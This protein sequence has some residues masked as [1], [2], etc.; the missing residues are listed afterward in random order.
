MKR[1]ITP[2]QLALFSRSPV[3][4]AWWEELNKIDPESAPKPQPDSL[5][6]L[7]IDFGHE[8][9][10][11]LIN[12]LIAQ[13]YRVNV[14]W[15][16]GKMTSLNFQETLDAMHNGDDYIYQACLQN[17]EL[18]GSVD[19]LQRIDKSSKLGP[20]SY[21][22]I[23]CKLSSHPKPIY[24]VQG[25]AY[26]E[27]LEPI[28]GTRPQHFKLYLGGKKFEKGADG[29]LVNDYWMW[30]RRLRDRYRKFLDTFDSNKQPEHAPGDHGHWSSFIE[31]ELVKKRDLILVA[32]MR[33]SQ[34]EK[35]IKAGIST[36]EQLANK[37]ANKSNTTTIP[38][39]DEN[40]FIRLKE[41][42]EIQTSPMGEGGR[43]PYKVRPL[44]E[45]TK[46]L[47]ML[48]E[49]DTGDIW[50]DMEG[51]PNPLTGKKLEYLFGACYKN[52]ED[53]VEFFPLWAHDEIQEEKAFNDFIEW[54]KNR[55]I[56]YPKL[57]V[58]HYANYEKAALGNL[59][60]KYKDHQPLW[61][62]WL[63]EEL[64]V[65]LYPIVRNGILLGAPS[66]SIKKVEKLYLGD[67]NEEISTAVDSVVQYAEWLKS[68]E[69]KLTG[70]SISSSERLQNLQDYN[71]KDCESTKQLQDFLID[72]QREMLISPRLNKFSNLEEEVLNKKL[73]DLELIAKKMRKEVSDPNN[74]QHLKGSDGLSFKHQK[75]VSYLIEF[76]ETEGKVEWWEFFNRRDQTTSDERYYDTEI[77]A[78]AR[79][80]GKKTIKKSEG[81]IYEF[82]AE[83]PLKL[84]NK[85][86]LNMSFSLAE[87]RK[88][89]ERLISKDKL[90]TNNNE[91]KKKIFS[92]VGNF[93]ENDPTK[94]VLKV[95]AKKKEY[96]DEMGFKELPSHCDLILF[97][98]Q[99]YQ[100]MLP[101]LV[102]QAKAWVEVKK[103][104]SKAMVHLLEKRKIPELI[105]L[106]QQICNTPDK[107]ATLLT[108]FL[109]TA[110]GIA[111]SL[112]G[113]PGTG[114]T[115]VTGELIARLVKEGKR[116]AVSSQT[117][118]AI[119]NLLKCV[120]EKA[121]SLAVNPFIVKIS[122]G[123]SKKSDK[124]SLKGT[125]IQSISQKAFNSEHTVLGA[126]VF[127]L[128]KECFS[129][130]PFDLLVVDEAGQVSLSNLL[131]MSQC[132]RNILL[133]GDQNQL[134]QPN[135]A[136]H[137]ENSDLSCLDYM[138]GDEKIVPTDR[139][140]FLATS[141]RMPPSL[142]SVVSELFYQGELQSCIS[143]SE[144]KILWEGLQQGLSF[145]PVEHSSN[146]SES[147]EEID[148]IE[149]LVNQLLGCSY[150]LVQQNS[151]GTSLLQ[152]IIGR[153]EILITAPYNLQV[154]RLER[155]L[156][157]KARIGTVDRFQGQ[158]AP[159]SIHS[160][161]ASDAENA[162]RGIGFVL[163][164][165]RLNVAI[166]R[167]QCLSI[168]VGSP[169]LATGIAGTV[170]G[171]MQLNR[172]CRIMDTA[173][174]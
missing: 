81:Y 172:L 30:Y 78:N 92:L 117:H 46:G 59:A 137:P 79:K 170:E 68:G 64:F 66:Y 57:H 50:F 165:D 109:S 71:E 114:K 124:R 27:L 101:D 11:I 80:I 127:S 54:V 155:R 167:A 128:V 74:D 48:P 136:A 106:N 16:K 91:D 51:Y 29:F 111:L 164:P 132:A 89:K 76:H 158:Q 61:E 77:I 10:K 9:E 5:D 69:A 107:V 147:K 123:T 39:L 60:L 160:L 97:P 86:G 17:D 21:I 42:A 75:L 73:R 25:C 156:S 41:Q 93:C 7:L 135:R 87:F 19:L 115:T 72:R 119:N 159:I 14:K 118:E 153:D 131:F 43:P 18:R 34:R 6:K 121:E 152:G 58:Y 26:C 148:R 35:L 102:R 1:Q 171:V 145:E 100:Y 63:R 162:P 163:D 84:S 49:G 36:I 129:E 143:K 52:N 24:L 56:A 2:T 168:V 120:D 98:R 15:V 103:P 88:K 142:T 134:S 33:Q 151:E 3:I 150:Q 154:N 47:E 116:I 83:Q 8:H 112:Q 133:V 130:E 40:M 144:N 94:I 141:W 105:K 169:S 62:E 139:G 161:T 166:S 173:T 38:D 95:G 90:G 28:L 126:T 55:R 113:P 32:G 53:K 37:V 13:G 20:W 104:F 82:K 4:G 99:I 149:Q 140:V 174:K 31:E 23:E 70:D 146:S 44:D 125:K 12:D 122:S 110:K 138:M 22:P 96:L 67:R 108:D 65:D 45:Q 85:P 157:S